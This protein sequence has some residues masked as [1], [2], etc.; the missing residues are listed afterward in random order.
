MVKTVFC[1]DV[2]KNVDSVSVNVDSVYINVDSVYVI[3]D[4]Y[5]QFI[6]RCGGCD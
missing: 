2:S 3:G 6:P 4:G 5:R 1:I